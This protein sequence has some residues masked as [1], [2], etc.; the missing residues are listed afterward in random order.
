MNMR[1]KAVPTSSDIYNDLLKKI[2]NL[3]YVPGEGISENE[4][5]E[6]Y[7]VTRHAIRGALAVLKEQGLIEV[8]PQKGTYVSLIDLEMIDNILFLRSAVEQETLHEIFK[9]KDN[10]SLVEKLREC[11]E[12]QM[13]EA[14]ARGNTERFYELDDRFHSL[15]LDAVG[16]GPV[17]DLYYDAYLHVRRWR[18]M[19]VGAQERTAELPREHQNII[20]AIEQGDEQA[21]RVS[22]DH[23]INSVSLFGN[24]IMAKYP[25]YFV[26]NIYA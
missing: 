19:E 16:R 25:W 1:Y 21:A 3:D 5:C 12:Q 7:G 11:I 15:L 13:Q 4:L 20:N 14:S 6:K 9:N 17:Q 26:Q 22:M 18:N 23:H 2:I 24:E 8:V 10:T